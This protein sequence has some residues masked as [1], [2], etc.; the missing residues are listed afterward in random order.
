MLLALDPESLSEEQLKGIRESVPDDLQIVVTRDKDDIRAVINEVEIAAGW[1][2]RDLL[3]EASNLRWYQQWSAG[4]DWLLRY[5]RVAEMD[6]AL[7][8]VSGIHAVQVTEHIFGF[9]L[10]FG[11]E[12]DRAI[13]AQ[14]R[15][16]WIPYHQHEGLFELADK[17][18]L[19]I[20]VGAIGQRTA[21]I[22]TAFGIHVLGVRRD[23]TT[24]VSGVKTMF[25][26]DQLP[27]LLPQADFVVLTV[28]LTRET[29]GM[30]GEPQLRAM[31]RTA[32]LINVGR[33]GT[34]DEAALHEALQEGWISGAALDVFETEPLPE[35][36]P[37]WELD[38][39]IITAHYAGVT[40]NYN[41][42]ALDLFVDNLRR[43][44]QGQPLR[45]VVDKGLGY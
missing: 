26:P 36:S 30:I 29:R 6:F 10:A 23:P 35:D 42:R 14:D 11:R 19:L 37:L 5:P 2:P 41:E 17:T 1:F 15:R 20:G 38:N 28:P 40:A 9:L 16:E 34:I 12:L 25:G 21:K 22:A 24:D 43:Y 4:A 31:K 44:R 18:M 8:N 27:H 45:N 13:R 3:P 32:Y 7:T 39:L 33:G